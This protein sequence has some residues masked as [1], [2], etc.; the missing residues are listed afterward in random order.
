VPFV[1]KLTQEEMDALIHMA[2]VN[3]RGVGD[4]IRFMLA[5]EFAKLTDTKERV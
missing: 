3:F 2:H 4:Q 5:A 1:L